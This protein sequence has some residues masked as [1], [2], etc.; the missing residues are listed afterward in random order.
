MGSSSYGLWGGGGNWRC[1]MEYR[2]RWGHAPEDS[3]LPGPPPSSLLPKGMRQT[4]SSTPHSCSHALHWH[5]CKSDWSQWVAALMPQN[6]EPKY[7]LFSLFVKHFGWAAQ[8][9]TQNGAVFSMQEQGKCL[10]S[11]PSVVTCDLIPIIIVNQNPW[12]MWWF[13]FTLWVLRIWTRGPHVSTITLSCQ[14]ELN[15][16]EEFP[17]SIYLFPALFP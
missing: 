5:Y 11:S 2:D 6:H 3:V 9:F 14:M 17:C 13:T 10:L 15:R 12:F 1:R 8:S 4:A 7:F 16:S